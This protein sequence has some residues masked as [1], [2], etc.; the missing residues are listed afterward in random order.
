MVV[1]S[2]VYERL[3][4]PVAHHQVAPEVDKTEGKDWLRKL[5]LTDKLFVLVPD[6]DEA[7]DICWGYSTTTRAN[8]NSS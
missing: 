1:L 7:G 5:N 2:G 6:L 4:V 3:S 8:R